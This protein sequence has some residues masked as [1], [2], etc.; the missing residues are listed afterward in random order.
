[1]RLIQKLGF[2]EVAREYIG[3]GRAWDGDSDETLF[4]GFS[5][6][7][8]RCLIDKAARRAALDLFGL[9]TEILHPIPTS[10]RCHAVFTLSPI[11]Y[12]QSILT[13]GFSFSK[14][15]L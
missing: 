9:S 4:L 3:E 5:F 12:A 11:S 10:S 13:L 6:L 8:G 2:G 1:M 15:R 14:S 7:A